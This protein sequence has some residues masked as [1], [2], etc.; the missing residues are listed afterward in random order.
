MDRL[1]RVEMGG[2]RAL[3]ACRQ[4]QEWYR[5]DGDPFGDYVAGDAVDEA[6]IKVLA[7]VTPSKIVAV[8]LNYRDHAKEMNKALPNEPLIFIKPSTAVIGLDDDIVMP[9][10]SSQVD[11]EAELGIVIRKRARAVPG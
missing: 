4:E 9:P 8:G 11:Y 3:G 5:L 10:S 2:A 7:P 6:Q 1:Y